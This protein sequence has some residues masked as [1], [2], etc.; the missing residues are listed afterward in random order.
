M[1]RR[2]L[3][4]WI[5]AG[6]VFASGLGILVL[7]DISRPATVYV[8]VPTPPWSESPPIH[9]AREIRGDALP[10]DRWQ[11]SPTTQSARNSQIVVHTPHAV[12]AKLASVLGTRLR[13][14]TYVS[15]G[16]GEPGDGGTWHRC[17]RTDLRS[18]RSF[19]V[20]CSPPAPTAPR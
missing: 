2:R 16:P 3:A 5:C 7:S 20:S 1:K 15:S 18:V 11:I 9:V 12:V 6:T 8:F 17:D 14:D 10:P 13:V 4:V 19:S